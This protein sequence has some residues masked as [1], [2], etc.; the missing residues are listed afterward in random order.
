MILE[1]LK[2]NNIRSYIT[3]EITFQNGSV[4]LSGDIGSGKSTILHSI[5]FAL[6]GI[7]RSGLSGSSLLRHGENKGSVELKFNVK[8]INY[9]IKRTLR[10]TVNSVT[11]DS[12]YILE[13]GIKFE[14][15]PIELKSKI[16]D[17]LGYPKELLTKSKSLIY[18]FTVYT[19]QEQMKQILFEDKEI[20][21]NTLRK[22]F[23]IDKYKSIKENSIIFIREL[24]KTISELNIKSE[25]F[26]EFELELKN[27][28]D[29]QNHINNEFNDKNQKLNSVNTKLK[30]EIEIFEKLQSDF[31]KYEELK[32]D[33]ELKQL[34]LST[35]EK[36]QFE[37][38]ENIELTNKKINNYSKRLFEFE[39]VN[40][41]VDVKELE[42]ELNKLEE[43]YSKIL[44]QKSSL[45][46][47]L[48]LNNEQT[49][50]LNNELIDISKK[51]EQKKI[52]EQKIDEIKLKFDSKKT[53]EKLLEKMIQKDKEY[54]LLL[55][56]VELR[57]SQS[58]E[59]INLIETEKNCPTCNQIIDDVHKQEVT[60]EETQKI[61]ANK[62]EKEKIESMLKKIE[63][64]I[65]KI[66]SNLDFLIELEVSFNAKK[67]ELSS[68]HI[69][70]KQ[71][72][73]KNE[74]L[75]V[76]KNE[77]LEINSKNKI[78][79]LE[80]KQKI[81]DLK[82]KL[83]K[84]RDN[85]LK[86]REKKNVLDLIK[87]EKINFE[88]YNSKITSIELDLKQTKNEIEILNANAKEFQEIKTQ[89]EEQNEYILK[90]KNDQKTIELNLAGINQE[91][92]SINNQIE[93]INKKLNEHENIKQKISKF[94]QIHEWFENFFIKLM[95]T[96]EKHVM[97]SIH[98]EFSSL[99]TEWF[100]I[101]IDD[102]D[103]QLDDEFTPR[104]IQNGYET[105]L[106]SLSGG[107]KTSI[108]LAYRLSLNKVIN[109]LIQNIN[110][111]ELIILDEPTDGFSTE[112]L[113][114]VRDILNE[115]DMAQT[116]I[117]S[118]EPKMESYV[119]NIIRINKN[120]G[121]SSVI[122]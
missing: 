33:I 98:R 57:L 10:R 14:G 114:R 95:T 74:Q 71:Y 1:G 36:S 121:I 40:E 21:L 51:I 59:L 30:N 28:K 118:H 69:F 42:L 39:N 26:Q 54:N 116:I 32:K 75:Q 25:S 52:I 78:D 83:S 3:Q 70:E 12:G 65:K 62:L 11:Q 88:T 61:R 101:L 60:L 105:D 22:V 99:L 91:L 58:N 43:I 64:N 56:K 122:S 6:F 50:R 84:T 4:L 104:I 72:N 13:N 90:I 77:K 23:G 37:I 46:E 41:I 63:N 106:D 18:R 7:M 119:E 67:L 87:Q 49:I 24:K 92:K 19:A 103:V 35:K 96:M 100:N 45:D 113:D 34:L 93:S 102:V 115:L 5:E 111:K 110:T 81:D 47:K 80:I 112:Q 29:K 20:R 79:D 94:N 68:I 66:K 85:N 53:Q 55:Q 2:L 76:L 27:L 15:T 73:E 89:F 9:V 120:D 16:L 109:D 44:Q 31:K 38:Q 86:F 8:N 17:I 48:K 108:A 107:E 117:V 97:I 82:N